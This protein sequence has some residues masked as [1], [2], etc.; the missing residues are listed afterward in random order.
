MDEVK[1]S[2]EY[3]QEQQRQQRENNQKAK[4]QAVNGRRTREKINKPQPPEMVARN[5]VQNAYSPVKKQPNNLISK[6]PHGRVSGMLLMVFEISAL[7]SLLLLLIFSSVFGFTFTSMP[8]LGISAGIFVAN[9]LRSV[10]VGLRAQNLR[11]RVKR[12]RQYASCLRGREFCKISDLSDPIG[13]KRN[14]WSRSAQWSVW[15][16]FRDDL[17]KM[18][19]ILLIS[20]E[21]YQNHLKLKEGKNFRKKKRAW[22]R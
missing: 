22:N 7:V 5:A 17:M 18:K 6:S 13:R 3:W 2:G 4:R 15:E 19:N 1:R 12:F 11:G 10:D 21:A 14:M 8:L 9:F 16:C 20:D